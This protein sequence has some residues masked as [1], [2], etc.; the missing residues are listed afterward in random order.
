MMPVPV[1]V[2]ADR[3]LVATVSF[4]I[5]SQIERA[6]KSLGS[7]EVVCRY[8]RNGIEARRVPLQSGGEEQI[9]NC[10]ASNATRV[11]V[12]RHYGQFSSHRFRHS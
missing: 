4:R 9:E 5:R 7:E 3:S 10:G 2:A 1:M 12:I 6:M 8:S 11:G